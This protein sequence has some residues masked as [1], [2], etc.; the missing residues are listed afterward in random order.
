MVLVG[1][2]WLLSV[3]VGDCHLHSDSRCE[4]SRAQTCYAEMARCELWVVS[5]DFPQ[6]CPPKAHNTNLKVWLEPSYDSFT[7]GDEEPWSMTATMYLSSGTGETVQHGWSDPDSPPTSLGLFSLGFRCEVGQDMTLAME[8]LTL[9][10]LHSQQ[11][12]LVGG[13]KPWLIEVN[14]SVLI[15]TMFLL[16]HPWWCSRMTNI[17]EQIVA[18]E[19]FLGISRCLECVR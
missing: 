16:V 14:P 6:L 8:A 2:C 17:D 7:L 18:T 13:Y 4:E 5:V 9:T 19:H 10:T 3:V 1:D 11:S 15:A 12:M